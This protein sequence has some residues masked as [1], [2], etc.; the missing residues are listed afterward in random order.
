M[1]EHKSCVSTSNDALVPIYEV[2]YKTSN[3][4]QLLWKRHT[5]ECK[6]SVNEEVLAAVDVQPK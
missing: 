6:Q 2:S 3:K 1:S 4:V 5:A